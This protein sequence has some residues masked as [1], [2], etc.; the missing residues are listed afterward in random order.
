MDRMRPP[1]VVG[2]EVL[3][4]RCEELTMYNN[5]FLQFLHTDGPAMLSI[6]L[7]PVILLGPFVAHYWYKLRIKQWE[8]SL[9][10]TM[11]EKGM[12]A[13]EIKMVLETSATGSE[14]KHGCWSRG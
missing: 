4:F 8:M 9:K 11:L 14:K 2:H 1:A 7:S 5:N 10:H 13:A 3:I 12:S 6:L